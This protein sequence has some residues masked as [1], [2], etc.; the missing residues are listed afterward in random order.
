MAELLALATTLT[1]LGPGALAAA[2]P[3]ILEAVEAR[4][5]RYGYGLAEAAPAGVVLIGIENCD[6][7]GYGGVAVVEGRGVYPVAV[8][9]C[10]QAAHE[11]LSARGLV[12]DVNVAELGHKRSILLLW[13]TTKYP[14]AN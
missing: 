7:L 6:L 5:V 11:P 8:V 13:T 10:Q 9:D 12:A 14:S 2:D 3:G 1:L 4:R